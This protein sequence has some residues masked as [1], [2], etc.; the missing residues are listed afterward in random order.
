MKTYKQMVR[1]KRELLKEL[2]LVNWKTYYEVSYLLTELAQNTTEIRFG[3][4]IHSTIV[5]N[6]TPEE[7]VQY[8]TLVNS[9][10]KH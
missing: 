1:S 2:C 5:L 8:L 9:Y 10:T 3:N 7:V 6:D 4:I